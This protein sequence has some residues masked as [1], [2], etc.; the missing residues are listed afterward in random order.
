[1]T[2]FTWISL[3]DS[4]RHSAQPR[5]KPVNMRRATNAGLIVDQRRKRCRTRW[6]NIRVI[7]GQRLMFAEKNIL[8]LFAYSWRDIAYS[9]LE[10]HNRKW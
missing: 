8:Y 10:W 3:F 5:C 1:M 9:S 2:S 4:W 7:L 6:H